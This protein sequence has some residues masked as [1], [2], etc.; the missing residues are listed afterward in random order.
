MAGQHSITGG[1]EN[2][3]SVGDYSYTHIL[4]GPP[5]HPCQGPQTDQNH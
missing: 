1:P 4:V 5:N 3:Y 2:S